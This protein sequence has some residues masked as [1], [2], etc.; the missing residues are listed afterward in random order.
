MRRTALRYSAGVLL[1]AI[2]SCA[3]GAD[4]SG[5]MLAAHNTVLSRAGV[6]P[7]IWSE[8]LACTTEPGTASEGEFRNRLGVAPALCMLPEGQTY[9]ASAGQ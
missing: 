7:L 2:A 8:K 5:A 3:R 9:V 6:P 1:A 4:S